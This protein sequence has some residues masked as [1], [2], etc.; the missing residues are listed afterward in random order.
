MYQLQK[1]EAFLIDDVSAFLKLFIPFP[2]QFNNVTTNS[3]VRLFAE[4]LRLIEQAEP[5]SD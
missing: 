1:I 2:Q 3:V 5:P 4:K